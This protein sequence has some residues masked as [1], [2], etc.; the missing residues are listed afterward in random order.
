MENIL[1]YTKR[2][3]KKHEGLR[4][5]VYKDSQGFITVGYGHALHVGS[6]ITGQMAEDFFE[7]DV[8]LAWF[9]SIKFEHTYKLDLDPVR[10]CIIV[11]MI[12]NMG[13]R[14]VCGFEKMIAALKTPNYQLASMEMLDSKW[15][16]QVKGRA[17]DLAR[18]ME[19]G[20]ML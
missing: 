19:T 18:M 14:K 9:D 12:F 13:Y 10:R 3:I 15:A 20:V 7:M 1:E 4:L 5:E 6:K 11:N 8:H 2:L 17:H 16:K